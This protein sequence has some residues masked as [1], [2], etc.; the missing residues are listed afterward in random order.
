[1]QIEIWLYHRL[2]KRKIL[3]L[4]PLDTL[5]FEKKVVRLSK[6]QSGRLES[7]VTFAKFITRLRDKAVDKYPNI[8]A[9]FQMDPAVNG[10][11]NTVRREVK[12]FNW[13]AIG[14]EL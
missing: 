9:Y 10:L 7:G 4:D 3:H 2:V 14:R 1:M 11:E 5:D 12:A 8:R 13:A 6:H